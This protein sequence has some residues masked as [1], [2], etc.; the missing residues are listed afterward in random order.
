[1]TSID[2]LPQENKIHPP[3]F[4]VPVSIILIKTLKICIYA[5][6]TQNMVSKNGKLNHINAIIKKKKKAQPQ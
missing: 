3:I 2:A 4:I 5:L 6:T 1:M